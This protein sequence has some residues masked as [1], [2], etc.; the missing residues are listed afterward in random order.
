MYRYFREIGLQRTLA[1][2]EETR[3]IDNHYVV[4]ATTG[5]YSPVS[6]KDLSALGVGL[7]KDN[8][9]DALVTA[10]LCQVVQLKIKVYQFLLRHD[11]PAGCGGDCKGLNYVLDSHPDWLREY[12]A[13]R[14]RQNI[15]SVG[16]RLGR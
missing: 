4:C 2:L 1:R 9:A 11:W 13:W 6:L 16:L 12:L 10:S 7:N 14:M 5:L 8:V 15:H 3:L